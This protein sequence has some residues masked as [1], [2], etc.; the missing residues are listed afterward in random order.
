MKKYTTVLLA[1]LT[2]FIAVAAGIVSAADNVSDGSTICNVTTAGYE[3]D[4]WS[5]EQ[6]PVID[7]CGEEYVPLFTTNGN[8]CDVHVNKLA[9]LILDSNET[10]TLGQGE[11]MYLGEGYVLEV[12]EISSDY[13]DVW[14]EL[15]RD[16]QYVADQSISI[17][18][19]NNKTWNVIL[20]NVQG[21]NDIVVMKVYVSN[22]FVGAENCIA[23]IDGIWL[24]DYGNAR[25]LNIGDKLGEFTLKEIINGTGASNLGSLVF[26]NSMEPALTS[27]VTATG[28]ECD[29]WSDEQYPVIDLFEAEYVP[30]F[31]TDGN[32]WDSH[33]NKLAGLIL[34][35]NQTQVLEAGEILDLGQGYALE[36]REIDIDSEKAWL[37]LTRDGQYIADKNVSIDTDDNRTWTVALDDVQGENNIVV[38]KVHVKNL[39]VG[40][41]K[42]IVW[43]DGVWLIDYANARTLNIGDE[44]GEFTLEQIISGIDASN[45]GSLVFEKAPVIDETSVTDDTSVNDT[46]AADF[47]ESPSSENES[48]KFTNKSAELPASWYWNFWKSLSMKLK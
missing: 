30:L 21:E 3:C 48:G 38:M 36:V 27:N 32:I 44:F 13:M 4:S 22:I 45:P 5:D 25:T 6:Y 17:E 9:R 28:Y 18:T 24:I 20:D 40:T 10:H 7:L 26:E 15:T 35:S 47:S 1:A 33:V 31:A 2:V 41:E 11:K 39:F 14:L 23:R 43:I 37:E 29:S 19:D 46:S 16:G 34:D 42:R 8:I 12:K